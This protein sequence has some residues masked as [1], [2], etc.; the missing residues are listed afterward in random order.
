VSAA[1]VSELT[2]ETRPYDKHMCG[3]GR[4]T[5]GALMLSS[6]TMPATDAGAMI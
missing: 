2:A 3:V 6:A 4:Y 1:P 5:I